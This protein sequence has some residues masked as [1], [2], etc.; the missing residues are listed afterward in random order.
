MRNKKLN[1]SVK[2]FVLILLSI[3]ILLALLSKP[4]TD[5]GDAGSYI[6]FSK[7]ILGLEDANFAHRSP[8]YSIIMA[9]FMLI[10]QPP[11]LYYAII[12]F[13]YLLVGLTAWMIFKIFRSLFMKDG[14]AMLISLLFNLSLST[15]YYA[16]IILTEIITVFLLVLSVY[17]FIRLAKE[18][19]F[20]R[21]IFLGIELGL[22]S[23]ARFNAIPLTITFSLL[24]IYIII[25]KKISLIST[26]KSFISF[27]VPYLI[28]INL[29]C[30]YNYTNNSFYGLF[31]RSAGGIPRN[32]VVA[33][34][35]TYNQVSEKN[36]PILAIFLKAREQHL[37]TTPEKLKGSLSRFDKLGI[38]NDLYSG[39]SIYSNAYSELKDFFYL[40]DDAGEYEMNL[41]LKSFYEEI[42]RQN[43]AF[44]IKMRFV[45]FFSSFRAATSSL[46]DNYGRINTNILPSLIFIIFKLG[47]FFISVFVFLLSFVFIFHTVK[48][49]WQADLPI[50]ISY[51]ILLSFWGINFYFITVNDANRYK[52]PAEPFLF[53]IF[54]YYS[55][56]LNKILKKF[57]KNQYA[58]Y[59]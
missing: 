57:I 25:Q 2:A 6:L 51:A 49:N 22:L 37:K 36:K 20:K 10:F 17:T 30:I 27:I 34:I 35:R 39:F 40:K 41:N 58:K 24:I 47:I 26:G 11:Y 43:R 50:L 5:L 21:L 52:F 1:I 4:I 23:L 44:I 9:G 56:S 32:V 12:Y 55:Y 8:L 33:S 48:N 53:G 15:I 46:P 59:S 45:S 31:P 38:L 3:N 13:Q 28:I 42:Y 14:P 19:S 16:N 18:F 54:I 29:W 7:V